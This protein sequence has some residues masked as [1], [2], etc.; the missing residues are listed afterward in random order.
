VGCTTL[1]KY[2]FLENLQC[3]V[4][5]R[6]KGDQHW[7]AVSTGTSSSKAYRTILLEIVPQMETFSLSVG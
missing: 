1:K 5:V 7:H 6:V 4:Q 2:I 3:V